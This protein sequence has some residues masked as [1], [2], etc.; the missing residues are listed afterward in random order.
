MDEVYRA[1]DTELGRDV[2]LK[3]LPEVFASDADRLARFTREAQ[4]LAALNHSN[5]AHIHGLEESGGVR[6]LVMELVD[7]EDLAERL[8]RGPIP[9]D[10]ALP[11]ARQIAGALEATHEQGIIHRDRN[12]PT[13][14]SATTER[15]RSWTSGCEGTAR[16]VTGLTSGAGPLANLPT[17]PCGEC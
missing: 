10:E 14:R 6:A 17:L 8:V 11:I 4:T 12:R 7:G 15:S 9:V 13:S 5:I 2:A 3:I 1:R 16:D